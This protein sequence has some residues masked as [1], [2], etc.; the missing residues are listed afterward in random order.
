MKDFAEKNLMWIIITIMLLAQFVIC[1]SVP[2]GQ[3]MFLICNI[4]LL[5]RDKILTRPTVD[6]IKNGIFASVSLGLMVMAM[7]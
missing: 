7:V 4:L 1:F 6:K 3:G 2:L 5:M